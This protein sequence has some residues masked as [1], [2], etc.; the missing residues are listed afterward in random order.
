MNGEADGLELWTATLALE[1]RVVT[2]LPYW[3]KRGAPGWDWWARGGEGRLVILV[4]T[5]TFIHLILDLPKP[6]PSP[7]SPFTLMGAS[8]ISY[9]P[10]CRLKQHRFIVRCWGQL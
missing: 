3:V 9:I 10:I 4:A 6:P 1:I 2:L 8:G 7:F 5:L